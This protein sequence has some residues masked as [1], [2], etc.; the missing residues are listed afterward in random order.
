MEN[1]RL[2]MIGYLARL[3][4]IPIPTANLA[5]NIRNRLNKWCPHKLLHYSEFAG[6]WIIEVEISTGSRGEIAVKNQPTITPDAVTLSRQSP[7]QTT[8]PH[9]AEIVIMSL[10]EIVIVALAETVNPYTEWYYKTQPAVMDVKGELLEAQHIITMEWGEALEVTPPA[11]ADPAKP[12]KQRPPVKAHIKERREK[13]LKLWET[14][15]Y[16]RTEVADILNVSESTIGTDS[17]TLG[18][19]WK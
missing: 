5:K 17:R 12:S 13:L 15:K 11:P 6:E 10:A 9:L 1:A 2:K 16:T 3:N 4:G 8:L 19:P 18:I 14:G 7:D